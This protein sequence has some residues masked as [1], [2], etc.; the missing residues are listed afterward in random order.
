[1]IDLDGIYDECKMA[2]N[3]YG[4]M[5]SEE[6]LI[7]IAELRQRQMD[8]PFHLIKI[9][10]GH[11]YGDSFWLMPVRAKDIAKNCAYSDNLFCMKDEEISISERSFEDFLYTIFKKHFDENLPENKSRWESYPSEPKHKYI[12]CF[13]WHLTDNFYTFDSIE[14][15]IKEIEEISDILEKD[16]DDPQLEKMRI[17]FRHLYS[18]M[19]RYWRTNEKLTDLEKDN[20]AMDNKEHILDFYKRFVA[21]LR[22][23]MKAGAAAGYKLIS[24]CGP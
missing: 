1:M 8:S 21:S 19:P 12:T 3:S 4:E 5:M 14:A 11:N 9:E 10:E 22:K 2:D 13:E 6:D 18:Y 16:Y 15:I 23:M 17:G 7:I 20:I 24:V